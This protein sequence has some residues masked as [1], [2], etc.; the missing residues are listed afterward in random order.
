[1]KID[2][3]PFVLGAGVFLLS[4][5]SI[6]AFFC[7]KKVS[8]KKGP[9]MVEMTSM[10]KGQEV[11]RSANYEMTLDDLHKHNG[12]T[13]PTIYVA[14][15]DIIFDVSSSEFYRPGGAYD[16]FA[17]RDASVALALMSTSV[18]DM[19][20]YTERGHTLDE[21]AKKILEDWFKRFTNKYPRVGVLVKSDAQKKVD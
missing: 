9:E 21:K 18:K 19:D 12:T 5:I 3:I 4:S 15:K 17:G 14:V 8:P 20:C 2:S 16:A 7:R 6:L 13:R 10:K 11:P 1:M